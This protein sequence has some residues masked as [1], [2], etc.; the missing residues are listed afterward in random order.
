MSGDPAVAGALYPH[1][2]GM[3][4]VRGVL[5][6]ALCTAAARAI[7]FA[8]GARSA[9][10]SAVRSRLVSVL[11]AMWQGANSCAAHCCRFCVAMPRL[12]FHWMRRWQR[13]LGVYVSGGPPLW[14][15]L[16][17]GVPVAVCAW[18]C[19]PVR[20]CV[21]RMSSAQ[22]CHALRLSGLTLGVLFSFGEIFVQAQWCR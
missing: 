12:I 3:V 5:G 16:I 8:G 18:C 2:R 14:L 21:C 20:R 19:T 13:L 17:G 4:I 6:G 7:A 1:V 11:F 10:C 9:M 22:E 15:Y